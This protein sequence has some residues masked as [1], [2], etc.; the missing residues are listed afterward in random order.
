MDVVVVWLVLAG[1]AGLA[2]LVA[3]LGAAWA[4]RHWTRPGREAH[5]ATGSGI[6]AS[7]PSTTGRRLLGAVAPGRECA[8]G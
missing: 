6:D 7:R 3:A 5:T 8:Q 1:E 2:L 4:Q